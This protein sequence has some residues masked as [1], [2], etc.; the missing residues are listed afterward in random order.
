MLRAS[1][2]SGDASGESAV[3]KSNSDALWKSRDGIFYPLTL[4]LMQPPTSICDTSAT[5][6]YSSDAYPLKEPFLIF[7]R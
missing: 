3:K 2:F 7:A 6:G 1:V 5:A 4:R